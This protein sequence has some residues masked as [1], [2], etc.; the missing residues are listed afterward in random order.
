MNMASSI[1]EQA[2]FGIFHTLS[3]IERLLQ[4]GNPSNTSRTIMPGSTT[5]QNDNGSSDVAQS[6][7]FDN[8]NDEG[9]ISEERIL[10]RRARQ[11]HN[12]DVDN[13]TLRIQ[14]SDSLYEF[15]QSLNGIYGIPSYDTSIGRGVKIPPDGRFHLPFTA[16]FL[17]RVGEEKARNMLF[18]ISEYQ[19]KF[20]GLEDLVNIEIVDY[21]MDPC[22]EQFMHDQETIKLIHPKCELFNAFIKIGKRLTWAT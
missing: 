4:Q 9:A 21:C 15:G 13:D 20:S 12:R 3:N 5:T 16:A 18:E 10:Y 7:N 19:S 2:L 22:I 8:R 14:G 17:Q 11:D 6:R 1:S